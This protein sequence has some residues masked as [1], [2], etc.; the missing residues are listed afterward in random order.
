MLLT[1]CPPPFVF[2][3]AQGQKQ[4]F[5]LA[6]AMLRHS[7]ILMLDEAT[8]SID[9]ETDALIQKA[10]HSVFGECTQLTIAHRCVTRWW[11]APSLRVV[12]L[13]GFALSLLPH[14]G[15]VAVLLY[16]RTL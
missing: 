2:V 5:C 6:R 4:L 8:A 15:T 14:C 12:T 3:S 13:R 11:L 16:R 1:S 10:I 9:P 7:R